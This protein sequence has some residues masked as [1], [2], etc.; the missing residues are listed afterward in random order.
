M[1]DVIGDI[2]FK[3]PRLAAMIKTFD[4]AETPITGNAK[5]IWWYS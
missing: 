2:A 4:S 3:N 5:Y 1:Q